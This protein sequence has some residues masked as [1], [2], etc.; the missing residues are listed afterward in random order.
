MNRHES[1]RRTISVGA[2]P[3]YPFARWHAAQAWRQRA[4]HPPRP[5]H[6][7]AGVRRFIQATAWNELGLGGDYLRCGGSF[8][9]LSLRPKPGRWATPVVRSAHS[10]QE[11]SIRRRWPPVIR[12]CGI[13]VVGP[14][15]SLLEGCIVR[16]LDF[17]AA[18]LDPRVSD[19]T[20]RE[21]I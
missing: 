14:L 17:N 1:W 12:S 4:S 18:K 3:P 7:P 2:R 9:I 20:E 6:V 13:C 15:T 5:C 8:D 19:I 16:P 21:R 10:H 11:A